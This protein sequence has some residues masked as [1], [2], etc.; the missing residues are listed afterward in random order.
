[1]EYVAAKADKAGKGARG[2]LYTGGED[3]FRVRAVANA[4]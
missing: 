1:M 3:I 2:N 4:V